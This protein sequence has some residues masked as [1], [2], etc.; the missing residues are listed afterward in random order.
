MAIMVIL[1]IMILVLMFIMI[2]MALMVLMFIMAMTS[3]R[4]GIVQSEVEAVLA[5]LW[6]EQHQKVTT[7]PKTILIKI[8]FS[9]SLSILTD[10]YYH[11]QRSFR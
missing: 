2:I 11:F 9:I 1:V 8:F 5:L 4:L 3:G 6:R 10:Q 7:L